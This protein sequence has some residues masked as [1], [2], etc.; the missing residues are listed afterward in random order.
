MAADCELL[1]TEIGSVIW[2][3]DAR[4]RLVC[5]S[6]HGQPAPYLVVAAA[7]DGARVAVGATLPA[8]LASKLSTTA[9]ATPSGDPSAPPASLARCVELLEG[10]VGDVRVVSGPSYVVPHGLRFATSA[11][12]V[13]SD[14]GSVAE[15][16][17]RA[18]E[19]AGWTEEEW[20]DLLAGRL[21]PW[22]MALR[23]GEVVSICHS[24]RL[25]ED[26]AEAGVWTAL[27]ARGQGHAAATTAAWAGLFEAGGP[28]LFYSTAADNHSSQ[29]VA[30]RLGL[31]SIGWLWRV[32]PA[33]PP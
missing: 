23:D 22:A 10:T 13:D 18:P 24:A 4:G 3:K 5:D 15:L 27:A 25:T 14:R 20:D 26:G 21:G 12:I 11:V 28:P 19:S 9:Q 30:E 33:A 29:R 2:T 6:R 16:R 31:R 7:L 17:D 32:V 1:A 8:P